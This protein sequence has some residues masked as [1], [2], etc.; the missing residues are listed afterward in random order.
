[1]YIHIH[2]YTYMHVYLSI[3]LYTLYIQPAYMTSCSS[4][5]G[6]RVFLAVFVSATAPFTYMSHM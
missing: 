3:D 1:M 4:N 6:E 2:I 5:C